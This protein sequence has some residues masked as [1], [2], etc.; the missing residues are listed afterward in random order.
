MMN[1]SDRFDR[2]M[3]ILIYLTA[4]S[5]LHN[6]VTPVKRLPAHVMMLKVSNSKVRGVKGRLFV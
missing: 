4:I 5:M 2:E 6:S 3:A 1:G